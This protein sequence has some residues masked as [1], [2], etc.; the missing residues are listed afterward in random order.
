MTSTELVTVPKETALQVFSAPNGLDPYLQRIRKEIDEFKP[1]VSTRKGREQVASIAHRV[2]R[3]KTYLDGVGKDLVAEL[4]D[5]PKKI[6]AERKRMR[7]MLDGWKD[8]VRQPLTEWE[9]AEQARIDGHKANIERMKHLTTDIANLDSDE[10]RAC[11]AEV[12]AVELGDH[13]EEFE[14][15]AARAKESS[16]SLL[17]AGLEKQ[18]KYE[19]EQAELASL[20][21]EA[22]ERERKEREER[23]AREAAE[24]AKREAEEE[25]ARVAAAAEAKAKAE[26]EAAERRELELKLAAE[27][28]ERERLEAQ[29]RAARAEQEAT[30]RAAREAEAKARKEQEEAERREANKRH[31]AKINNEAAKA[32]IKGGLSEADAKMVVTMIAK[33]EVPHISIAY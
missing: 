8:E 31:A 1:D 7:D 22:E 29:E 12:E 3:S 5:I 21:A 16:L 14:T 27:K 11:I 26:R 30:E 28:A 20:R 6:D 25:A 33:K 17:R 19:A 10:L 24:R 18:Q 13:W 32:L 4:K 9:Q 2:A 15:E 23:I